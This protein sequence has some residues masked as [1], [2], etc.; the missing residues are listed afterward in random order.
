MTEMGQS[1]K[2][3][4][5]FSFE[6]WG[7]MWYSKQHYATELAKEHTVYFISPPDK[8]RLRDLL[9]FRLKLKTTPEGVI[10]VDYRNQLPLRLLPPF[11]ANWTN[12]LAARK[13]GR[14]LRADGNLLWYFHPT[15]IVLQPVLRPRGTRLIYHVVDPY[16]SFPA[17]LPC[18]LA[19]DVVVTVNQWF[20]DHY[21]RIN[22]NTLLIPHGVRNKDRE[23]IPA[24]REYYAKKWHPYVIMAGGI[25]YRTNYALLQGMAERLPQLNLILAGHLEP[26]EPELEKQRDALLSL[27]NVVHVGVQHPNELRNLI[28]ACIA[29]LIT[30]DFEPALETPDKP[31]GTPLKAL[32]YLAQLR[33]V[34]S[35]I[36]CYIPELIGHGV[37]K[38]ENA[39][40]FIHA[41]QR[42]MDGSMGLDEA[43]VNAYLDRL[44]YGKLIK[45]IL[46][47]LPGS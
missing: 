27:P 45:R 43:K 14:L 5:I 7:D 46:R 1:R 19:A 9:S 34:I 40:D 38:M 13:L 42:A 6:P 11:L 47:A 36:N 32:N 10:V 26:L 41:V 17:D 35:N 16:Q 44:S 4:L 39:E 22:P 28:G 3:I 24:L 20:K 29:G 8:W 12:W 30:Y 31:T 25:T 37:Y 23:Q 33:P 2:T 21:N 18:A 15:P